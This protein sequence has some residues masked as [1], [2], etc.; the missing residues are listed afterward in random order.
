MRVCDDDVI[1][2]SPAFHAL[3]EGQLNLTPG[4]FIKIRKQAKSGWWEG[5]L[6]S[7]GR[8]RQAGW[9]PSNRVEMLARGRASSSTS[10]LRAKSVSPLL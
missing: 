5:E 7:R 1:P 4:E 2:S 10:S 6:Q 8:Q 3:Q 9:F